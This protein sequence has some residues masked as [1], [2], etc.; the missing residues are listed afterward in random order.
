MRR[1]TAD[2]RRTASGEGAS[3]VHPSMV[4]SA[5]GGVGAPPEG[6]EDGGFTSHDLLSL[7]PDS[8]W[9]MGSDEW[10]VRCEASSAKHGM[11]LPDIRTP[12]ISD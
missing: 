4:R 7:T 5:N 11:G 8:G 1:S 3:C 12:C 10:V 9:Q 2:R 6:R